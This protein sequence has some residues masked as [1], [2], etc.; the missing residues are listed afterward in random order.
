MSMNTRWHLHT[1]LLAFL[2]VSAG[3]GLAQQPVIGRWEGAINLPGMDLGILVEFAPAGDSLKGTI[4][5][6]MQ[7]AKGLHLHDVRKQNS[8]IQF[9]LQAGPGIARFE[10]TLAGDSISGTFTQA[11]V[12]C[13]F[14]LRRAKEVQKPEPPPYK[15]EEV[16]IPSDSLALA[17]TLTVPPTPGPHPAA[18][19]LTGSGAQTRDEEVAGFPVFRVLADQLTRKGFAVLRCDDRGVGGST[20][21]FATATTDDFAMDALAQWK[22]LSNR[23]DIDASRLGLIGHSEG[24]LAAAIT[25]R[26]GPAIGFAVLLAGPAVR[27]DSIILGQVERMARMGGAPDSVIARALQSQQRVVATVH[28]DTGWKGLKEVL[29]TEMLRSL[30]MATPEQRAAFGNVDSMVSARVEF[31]IQQVKSPWFRRFTSYDPAGDI[32]GMTCP[33]LALFGALDMQVPATQN[34]RVMEQLFKESGNTRTSCRII[35]GA[36]HLFQVAGTGSPMEYGQL[37]KEFVPRFVDDIAEWITATVS[38]N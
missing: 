37:K 15:E 38:R 35:P 20:G 34:A 19:L 27:G 28:A 25:C 6:P 14:V 2:I 10:G 24:A 36:N 23:K 3:Q 12:K 7:M 22:F 33:V 9:A 29:R 8:A 1:A 11:T 21:E 5:I 17:G 32:R 31:Q 13:P 26:K 4:D 16:N 30:S 18:I